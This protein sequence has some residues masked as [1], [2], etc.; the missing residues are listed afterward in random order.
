MP[1]SEYPKLEL[2]NGEVRVSIYLPDAVHGYY[3]GARSGARHS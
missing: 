2:E 1:D 3:R